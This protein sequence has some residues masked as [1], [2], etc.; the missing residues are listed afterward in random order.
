MEWAVDEAAGEF[1]AGG[2]AEAEEGGV[3]HA[4]ELGLDGGGEVGV[5]VA[6]DV[7]P[8]GGV[9]VV[10]AASGGVDE[11]GAFAAD[12]GVDGVGGGE[13]GGEVGEGVPEVVAI[14][15]GV[16]FG[17]FAVAKL[18]GIEGCRWHVGAGVG[19]V[20]GGGA[21]DEAGVV[22]TVDFLLI[23]GADDGH[24]R[25]DLCLV[26][27]NL[28]VRVD[29]GDGGGSGGGAGFVEVGVVEFQGV[30][31]GLE[32][33]GVLSEGG[34]GGGDGLLPGALVFIVADV[35]AS[36]APG[37]FRE[38]ADFDDDTAVFERE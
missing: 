7:A 33:V 16:G 11:V 15:L 38:S 27:V 2:V 8:D 4:A 21:G 31:E 20:A 36:G 34:E 32:D 6:V 28:V 3:G 17:V 9:G 35:D 1:D 22:H 24:D 14:E 26:V 25:G 13:P 5:A 37:I 12:D 10:E 30:F 23:T 29:A 19:L 18:G